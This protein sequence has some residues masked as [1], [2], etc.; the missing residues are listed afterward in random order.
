MCI[1]DRAVAVRVPAEDARDHV[2]WK[3]ER[4]RQRHGPDCR[5]L[6]DEEP[7]R[8]DP[9]ADQGG[10]GGGE[11]EER[12]VEAAGPEDE[13]RLE[14]DRHAKVGTYRAAGAPQPGAI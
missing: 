9:P 12:A 4:L 7:R 3:T 14:A 8:A 1:R 10:E 11:A 13:D 5:D 6:E 2:G